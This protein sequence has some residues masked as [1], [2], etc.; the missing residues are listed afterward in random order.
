MCGEKPVTIPEVP[1]MEQHKHAHAQP[2][3]QVDEDHGQFQGKRWL[4]AVKFI[5]SREH[6]V[7]KPTD[8][9]EGEDGCHSCIDASFFP[10]VVRDF[11]ILSCLSLYVDG[12]LRFKEKPDDQNYHYYHLA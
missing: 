8:V 4:P 7:G 2:F 12:S 1:Q 10:E 3:E 6:I 5:A 11:A 9:G